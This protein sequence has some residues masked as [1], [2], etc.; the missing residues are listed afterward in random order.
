MANDWKFIDLFI[1]KIEIESNT[2]IIRFES[3]EL[4]RP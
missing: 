1:P 4:N 2:R 3:A